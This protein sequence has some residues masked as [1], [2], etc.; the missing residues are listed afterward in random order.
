MQK[1][2]RLPWHRFRSRDTHLAV[3]PPLGFVCLFFYI[4]RFTVANSSRVV[5]QVMPFSMRYKQINHSSTDYSKTDLAHS[6]NICL[7]R[8]SWGQSVGG[9]TRPQRSNK[10]H[11]MQSLLLS[12]LISLSHIKWTKSPESN[13]LCILYRYWFIFNKFLHISTLWRS[14]DKLLLFISVSAPSSSS[15]LKSRWASR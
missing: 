5:T 6:S 2:S 13:W 15:A 3:C 1:P 7:G 8:D 10:R 9:A 11:C 14:R 12:V 4:C